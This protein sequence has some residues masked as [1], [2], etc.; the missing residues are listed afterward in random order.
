[1]RP[2]TALD[3]APVMKQFVYLLVE[4][5]ADPATRLSRNR[6]FALFQTPAGRRA[7]RLHRHLTSLAADL[8]RHRDEARWSVDD[9]ADGFE[10]RLEIPSLSLV[11]TA[12]LTSDDV[13]VLERSQGP[14]WAALAAERA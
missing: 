9:K 2:E 14:L 11:R 10:V 6:H 8:V 4:H 13:A 12:F 1:M 3:S 5:L 7:L